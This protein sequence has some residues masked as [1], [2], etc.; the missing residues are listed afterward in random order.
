MRTSPPPSSSRTYVKDFNETERVERERRTRGVTFRELAH[1]YL[2][3]LEKVR[4]AKPS[5]IRSHQSDLAE[6][7]TPH[8]RGT[9]T[10][11]GL[12]MAALG[13]RPAAKITPAEVEALLRTVAATGVSARSVNRAREIVCAAFNYG[14]KPTT[15]SLPTNPALGTDRRRVPEPGVLLFYSP[16]EIEAIARSLQAGFHRPA[17]LARGELEHFEDDR[18][19][20]AIRVAAYSGLRLGE[21]L[22]LRW[23]DVDWTGSAL[24]ISRS[25][26]SGV[27]GTTKTGHVRRVPMADQA[28]AALDR[29]SQRQDFV[30]P[31]DYVFCNALGRPL[32]GSALRRRYK[33]ARDAAGLRP[34]RWHD[35]RHTFGSLLVAGGVD[36]V[37]IKDA[38]G[39]SQLTTTSRYLHARPAT[40]RAAAFTAAFG[41]SAAHGSV[42]PRPRQPRAARRS[43][44]RMDV[45]CES[46]ASR[47][48]P[49]LVG[50]MSRLLDNGHYVKLPQ[51][52]RG[53][54]R[55][56]A[57]RIDRIMVG[58]SIAFERVDSTTEL[59][60][61]AQDLTDA[62]L[63]RLRSGRQALLFRGGGRR[64]GETLCDVCVE[65]RS[66]NTDAP[67]A[68]TDR[69][70]FTAVDPVA[71]GLRVELERLGDL[72]D[73][74][75]VPGGFKAD[76]DVD[77]ALVESN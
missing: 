4:G 38:M 44:A 16:E 5:T 59:S 74:Q 50:A 62:V 27:E 14:M 56:F 12:V 46:R 47:C 28:A 32:D 9:G 61:F 11:A 48:D 41:G 51:R 8:K 6:P 45:S 34:L 57:R 22:A 75:I 33:R 10:T 13:D 76:E 3:W 40:E 20:E 39:H 35:L 49:R 2:E 77:P 68:D 66:Q 52:S 64:I 69:T 30:S 63:D 36:L 1:G 15:Y 54:W 73:C 70:E 42:S 43:V 71:D 31:D 29:L 37:S 72:V 23:R 24:T 58:G 17:V 25:L 67:S 21:L 53:S 18:D 26:S 19:G 60:Y 7:G 55:T 65:V